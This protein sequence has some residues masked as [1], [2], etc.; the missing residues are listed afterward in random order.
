MLK[1]KS[2]SYYVKSV[3]NK[4]INIYVSKSGLAKVS[5]LARHT[6][7]DLYIVISKW[8]II[9]ASVFPFALPVPTI[10][11]RHGSFYL[12]LTTAFANRMSRCWSL[13][14]SC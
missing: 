14:I 4:T 8:T 6:Q 1:T 2:N 7:R 11:F 13:T 10:R 9:Y 12:L 5:I 3:L